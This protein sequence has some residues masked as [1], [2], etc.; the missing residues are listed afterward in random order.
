MNLSRTQKRWFTKKSPEGQRISKLF[1]LNVEKI[2]ARQ[3]SLENGRKQ[4][5]DFTFSI[6]ERL[7]EEMSS[8]ESELMNI[9]ENKNVEKQEIKEYMDIWSVCNFWPKPNNYY[10]LRKELKQLNKRYKIHG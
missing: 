9:L 7:V 8:R 4:H 3:L 10:S 1:F 5:E 2:D 6:Q